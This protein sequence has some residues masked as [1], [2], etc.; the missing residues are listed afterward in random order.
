MQRLR[1][2]VP[3]PPSKWG[4]AGNTGDQ[5]INLRLPTLVA[6]RLK[7]KRHSDLGLEW[8][9]CEAFLSWPSSSFWANDGLCASRC[10]GQFYRGQLR[11][12]F[13][14][15]KGPIPP[16]WPY[17]GICHVGKL[18]LSIRLFHCKVLLPSRRRV[19]IPDWTSHPVA[20]CTTDNQR[21]RATLYEEV[22]FPCSDACH[23]QCTIKREV[24]L[25]LVGLDD[26][27]LA[28]ACRFILPLMQV[29]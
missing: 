21:C 8:Q 18:Q 16:P 5:L 22:K 9:I 27:Q 20:G 11:G 24:C 10:Q 7:A 3:S 23:A 13:S 17:L 15:V 12:L 2:R 25:E 1:P 4:A 26:G 6:A 28:I 14:G 19:V 29:P